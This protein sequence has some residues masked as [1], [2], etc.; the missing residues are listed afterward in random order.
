[1]KQ[2]K[3][4][5]L[6]GIGCLPFLIC[7]T[8]FLHGGVGLPQHG[9]NLWHLHLQTYALPRHDDGLWWL[10]PSCTMT[11]TF[12]SFLMFL[13]LVT[14]V[15]FLPLVD[16]TIVSIITI[17]IIIFFII[18]YFLSV[19]HLVLLSGAKVRRFLDIRKWLS[20]ITSGTFPKTSGDFPRDLIFKHR[21]W[22]FIKHKGTKEQRISSDTKTTSN[23]KVATKPCGMGIKVAY[24]VHKVIPLQAFVATFKSLVVFVSKNNLRFFVSL[25]SN[26]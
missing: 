6:L 25:C 7:F 16:T 22:V 2:C 4:N 17:I 14:L 26:I 13:S 8:H 10:W 20:L 5:Y 24:K 23:L 18:F 15:L 9:V 1:M 21:G 12:L 19:I 11:V 3:I